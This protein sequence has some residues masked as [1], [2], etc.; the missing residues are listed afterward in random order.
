M[1]ADD[2]KPTQNGL[3]GNNM[4]EL[5]RANR[6]S[7]QPGEEGGF[8][9]TFYRTHKKLGEIN[10]FGTTWT[11][12]DGLNNT[13][14]RELFRVHVIEKCNDYGYKYD[15]Q[16]RRIESN[17]LPRTYGSEDILCDTAIKLI[18]KDIDEWIKKANV[19]LAGK[20]SIGGY[21]IACDG[22]DEVVLTNSGKEVKPRYGNGNWAWATVNLNITLQ[23]DIN[24]LNTETYVSMAVELVSG[25]LK[26][27][28]KIGD[29][30]YNFTSFKAEAMVDINEQISTEDKTKKETVEEVPKNE[31][32][33][34]QPIVYPDW[35]VLKKDGTPNK[36]S[37]ERLQAEKIAE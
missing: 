14:L 25:Q 26:K 19:D 12:M 37:M 7:V 4:S 11:P 20:A 13:A 6:I 36:K 10:S 21:G 2:G 15:A 16:D 1:G 23:W 28:T 8:V 29:G 35:V 9:A 5:V 30:G 22:V 32:V 31:Q 27:P 3:G 17:Q 34:E 24:E 18:T 33:E